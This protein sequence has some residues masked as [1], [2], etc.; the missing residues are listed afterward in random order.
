MQHS[1]H[2]V[3]LAQDSFVRQ[4]ISPRR[5]DP[6]YLHLS[7]LLLALRRHSTQERITVLDFGCGGSPYRSLFPNAKYFRADLRGAQGVDFE[8]NE[9]GETNAPS[10]S[11]DLVLST[12]VL[13]H[14]PSPQTYLQECRRILRKRGKLLLATH[15]LFEE[16]A[17]PVDFYRWTEDGLRTVLTQCGF[18]LDSI[19]RLTMGPRAGFQLLQSALSESNIRGRS[20]LER[21]ILWPVWRVLLAR[22]AWA[23]FLD[24]VF[25]EY[26]VSGPHRLPGDNFYIDL[27][28][29]ARPLEL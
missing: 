25:S 22:R 6:Y 12:Q 19:A 5:G 21:L 13:E 8:I 24:A 9:G 10:D 20:R 23:P 29:A 15:G 1:I 7:D 18:A 2:L 14:C 4:R 26:R 3:E 16:H 11:F 27:L 17:C 28:A